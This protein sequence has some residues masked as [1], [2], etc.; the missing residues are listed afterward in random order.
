[1]NEDLITNFKRIKAYETKVE[2]IDPETM[3]EIDPLKVQSLW[4]NKEGILSASIHIYNNI[5]KSII[6]RIKDECRNK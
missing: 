5:S 2:F 3:E 4:V 6:V 1:M